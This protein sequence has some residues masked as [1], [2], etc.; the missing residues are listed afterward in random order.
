MLSK[1]I[2][3]RHQTYI[4]LIFI[5]DSPSVAQGR[6]IPTPEKL[7]NI[8]RACCAPNDK[9]I[10]FC[11]HLGPNIWKLSE[12]LMASPHCFCQIYLC[13]LLVNFFLSCTPSPEA[14][15]LENIVLIKEWKHP[16]IGGLPCY[17]FLRY[18]CWKIGLWEE[19]SYQINNQLAIV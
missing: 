6:D 16:S 2:H 7:W 17:L 12:L 1:W 3:N 9:I 19:I 4:N 18:L 14:F 15:S 8:L 5:C 11:Y 13:L 10:L